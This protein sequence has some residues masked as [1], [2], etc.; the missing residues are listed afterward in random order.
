[1]RRSSTATIASLLAAILQSVPVEMLPTLCTKRSS[2]AAWEAIK[3]IRVG[4][5]RVRE[6]K[7][8]QLWR[9]FAA[10]AWKEGESAEDFS[11][12]ISGLANNLRALGD[13]IADVVVVRKMLEVVPEHLEAI[14]VATEA[15]LDLNTVTVE[16]VT[17]RLRT[18]EQRR[19]KPATPVV[20]AQGRLLLTQEEWM[21]KL[22][23]GGNDTDKGSSSS[24]SGGGAGS[25]S[26][27]TRGR[28]RGAGG[29]HQ[30][31]ERA[32]STGQA[33]KPR[34]CKYCGKKG[35]WAKECWSRLRDEA[36]LAQVAQAEAED[37]EPT[38]LMARA[39]L[40]P[41]ASPPPLT[42]ASP[43]S[44]ASHP[45][46]VVEA[47]VFAQL[48]GEANRDDSLWY[49]DSGATNHMT[50]CRDAFI[51]INTAIRGFVKFGDGS[52]VQ[53]EGSG[54]VPFEGK[55]GEHIPLTGVY[56]IPRL[57]SNIISLGQ[58][59]EGGCDVH[60]KHGVLRIRDDNDRLIIRVKRTANRLYL[61]RV[62]L[63]Q[64]LCLAARSTDSAWL[65]HERYGHLHF[66]TLHKLQ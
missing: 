27:G 15:F 46:R 48:D 60:I 56:F 26:S 55:T 4:V 39:T 61:L 43:T 18:V 24:S 11:I 34:K 1:M 52:E 62:K 58:L 35:H 7:A 13:D 20:D 28:G 37:N 47:K 57:T 30:G 33:K 9:E 53:I 50:G 17:G 3:T 6:S 23:I 64:P 32:D 59:E 12:R 44:P 8:Q 51:D 5:E 36:Y 29:V 21:A 49:L 2:R 66:D 63:G 14:A 45:L 16:E 10:I 65:W 40:F 31:V 38:L 19:R 22:K 54:T 42:P 41:N 25:K